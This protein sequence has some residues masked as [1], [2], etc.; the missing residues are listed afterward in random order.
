M[1]RLGLDAPRGK[2]TPTRA[3]PLS[4][5][6]P[7][8]VSR[9]WRPGHPGEQPAGEPVRDPADERH[10]RTIVEPIPDHELGSG[11]RG[12]HEARYRRGRVMGGVLVAAA[13]ASVPAMT[14]SFARAR[15][16]GIGA[17]TDPPCGQLRS[18]IRA[19]PDA[20]GLCRGE[21]PENEIK[22]EAS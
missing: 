14:Q 3:R 4:S 18:A 6:I 20:R 10:R 7:H 2:E 12:G 11:L 8:W 22:E 1:P 21:A 13:V 16:R 15:A 19:G 5:R 9:T 17:A